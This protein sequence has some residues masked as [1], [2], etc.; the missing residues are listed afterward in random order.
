MT[1][2]LEEDIYSLLIA[3]PTL[4][5]YPLSVPTDGTFPCVVYQRISTTQGRYMTGNGL[6]KIRYQLTCYG[7]TYSSSLSA[8]KSVKTKFDLNTTNF[9]LAT[10][11]NQLEAKEVET[12]LYSTILEFYIWSRK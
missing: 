2:I 12:G 5:A 3:S 9:V 10:K 8:A 6:E 1:T 4:T 7:K 11:E